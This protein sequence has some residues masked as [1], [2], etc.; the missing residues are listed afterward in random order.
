M[1]IENTLK[2]FEQAIPNP[3]MKDKRVQIGCHIEEFGEMLESIGYTETPELE[4]IIKE[5]D[6]FKGNNRSFTDTQEDMIFH[7]DK[8]ALL[9]SLIDQIVTAVGVCHM[10]GFDVEGALDEVNRSNF[11]KFENGKPVFDSNG[12]I[13]KGV[14]YTKPDLTQFV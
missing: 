6:W 14:N 11:S 5:A 4:M 9:D 3:T 2:W 12:K 1:S 10:M 13:A 7:C 8:D